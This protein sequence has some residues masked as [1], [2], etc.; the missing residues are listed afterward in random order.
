MVA[1]H[2]GEDFRHC[3]KELRR[4]LLSRLSDF[5]QC[6]GRRT[7]F[8]HRY[9]VLACDLFNALRDQ[10][11]PLRENQRRGIFAPV[12]AERDRIVRGW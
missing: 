6:L 11:F 4:D 3:L 9:T 12:I 8:H 5:V 7:I 2:E 10:V 1:I